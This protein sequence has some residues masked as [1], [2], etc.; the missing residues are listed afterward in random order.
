M[1]KLLE[2][3]RVHIYIYMHRHI[4]NVLTIK[5]HQKKDAKITD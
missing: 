1:E 2:W 3:K 4:E 5:V